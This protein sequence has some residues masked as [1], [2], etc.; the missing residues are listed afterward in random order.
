M[1][2]VIGFLSSFLFFGIVG[3]IATII[4]NN[5]DFLGVYLGIG[6]IVGVLVAVL[7]LGVQI[8]PTKWDTREIISIEKDFE[9]GNCIITYKDLKTSY[10]EK[11]TIE[12]SESENAEKPYYDEIREE[13]ILPVGYFEKQENLEI[14]DVSIEVNIVKK[15]EPKKEE[16]KKEDLETKF[17]VINSNPSF[18]VIDCE[19]NETENKAKVYLSEEVD[20]ETI[21]K[22]LELEIVYQ[23]NIEKTTIDLDKEQ[24]ILPIK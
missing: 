2:C 10:I 20:S 9:F 21:N 23:K 1:Y 16:P 3:I 5:T 22:V 8:D 15:E 13:F 17:M 4:S 11:E 18:K 12:Y 14:E 7:L 6:T 19:I 24:V